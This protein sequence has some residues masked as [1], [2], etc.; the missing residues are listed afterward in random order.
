MPK[1]VQTSV[2]LISHTSKV[3]LKILQAKLPQYVNQEVPDV[4]ERFRKDRGTR[5]QVVNICCFTEKAN[6]FQKYIYFCFTADAK[7]FDCMNHN[8]GKFLKR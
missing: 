1:N 8:C 7:A 5:D 2:Q 4:Q 6:G 3:M